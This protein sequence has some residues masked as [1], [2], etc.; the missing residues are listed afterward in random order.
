[1]TF[2]N[3]EEP[4]RRGGDA[5]GF[6]GFR[7]ITGR[8]FDASRNGAHALA[9]DRRSSAGQGLPSATEETNRLFVPACNRAA[10]TA[11]PDQSGGE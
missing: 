1:M 8:V 7:A 2:T 10:D 9:L 3:G 5:G 11:P 6:A 4:F